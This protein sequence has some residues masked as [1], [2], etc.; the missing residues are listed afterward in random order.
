METPAVGR[1]PPRGANSIL[2][3]NRPAFHDKATSVRRR[4]DLFDMAAEVGDLRDESWMVRIQELAQTADAGVICR[5]RSSRPSATSHTP[6]S[7]RCHKAA[8]LRPSGER[9]TFDT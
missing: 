7:H 8:H 1:V 6:T 3:D 4:L 5:I 2:A 9:Q